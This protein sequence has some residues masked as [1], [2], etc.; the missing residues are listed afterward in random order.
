MEQAPTDNK[1]EYLKDQLIN[2]F[3]LSEDERADRLLNIRDL[4]NRR[5]SELADTIFELSR[6]QPKHPLL[7]RIFMRALPPQLRNALAA[8]ATVDLRDLALEADR[9]VVTISSA[10]DLNTSVTSTVKRPTVKR[11]KGPLQVCNVRPSAPSS[12]PLLC[13]K[14]SVSQQT[15]LVDTGAQVSVVPA[16][17]T[18]RACALT[19]GGPQ[20]QAANG[21]KIA[22]YGTVSRK[23]C[24]E[25]R[26]F[27]GQFIQADVRRPLLG[28]DFLLRNNLLVDIAGQRLVHVDDL[29]SIS[30]TRDKQKQ[31]NPRGLS[32]VNEQLDP[33]RNILR[34]FPEI[35]QPDFSLSTP[36]HGVTH[37][38]PT[39]GPPV[40][41][42]PRRL[43][44]VK[45]AAAKKEFEHLHALGIIRPS[46][47]A[48]ASPLHMVKKPNGE[49][50][51]CGDYRRLNV[52]STP[53]RYP[54]PHIQDFVTRLRGAKVFST[55]D[56]V[57]GYHQILMAPS[58]IEKTAI[59]TP[60]GLWEFVRMPFGLRN[61]G[62]T[63]Q[64]M[65]DSVLR[66]LD[67]VFVY[68]DDVLVASPSVEEH[69]RDLERVFQRLQQ[70]GLLLRPDKCCF[71]ASSVKFLGHIVDS[72]GI[73]PM[74]E[75][76]RAV[77]DFPKP[78]TV[79]ELRTFLGLINFYHRFLPN[80]ASVLHP[81]N[82]LASQRKSNAPLQWCDVSSHA[83]QKAKQLLAESTLLHHPDPGGALA[84]FTDAS[85]IGVGAS[86]QQW[87]Q[88]GW[89]PLAFFSRRLQPRERKYSTFDR[90]LLAGHL[91]AR[92]FRHML[93]GT[94][95]VLYT[96]HKP[97]VEAWRKAGDAW[98]ARQQRHLSTIAEFFCDV[99]Y[100]KG[101]LNL[102]AD[103]LSRA[104][105]DA[106]STC[107]SFE[108][109]AHAQ[110]ESPDIHAA[111]T[112]ITNLKLRDLRLSD[113]GPSVLCDVSQGHPRPLIPPTLRRQIF[114]S[115]HGLSHPGKRATRRLISQ[116]YVWH[117]MSAD[118]NQW[119]KD[120][121]PCHSSKV[122]NHVHSPVIQMPVPQTPFSV[123]HV[124]IVGPLP[125]SSGYSYL[126]TVIDRFSRW[127]EAIP[128]RDITSKECAEQ[129][130]LHWVAR[131]GTPSDI[132]SDRGRQ[133]TSA[134]WS[135]MSTTLKCQ[136]HHTS[137][138]HPQSNG[139]IERWHR[140]LKA[141]LRARLDG[142]DWINQLP[143][144]LLGL[145]TTPR[146][147]SPTS[148]AEQIYKHHVQLPGDT[149]PPAATNT[150]PVVPSPA[151]H[152]SNS[153]VSVPNELWDS[154]YVFVRCDAHR[155]PLERPYLGP[156]RVVSRT[157]K[158]FLLDLGNRNDSVSV[159]RLKPA[160]SPCITRS[161]RVSRPPAR[162]AIGGK[163]CGCRSTSN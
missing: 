163:P 144:V 130:L 117:R 83:F 148:P 103:A 132:I 25:G 31:L 129:F 161:G 12:S 89:V 73:R 156:Y 28:A 49:W 76:V 154:P 9:A 74:P 65:M 6:S 146:D 17:D 116:R 59:T 68:I 26:V 48:Y 1:Y 112:S 47:S 155:S 4:G 96:D 136:L 22:T 10:I 149:L 37:H 44:P 95:S 122:Q 119:C 101:M 135:H 107:I 87:Q 123:V 138:Y 16:S 158:T 79:S 85:D 100:Q 128:L 92:H 57:R 15:F 106:V 7:R 20:L 52:I 91:A 90:E 93:E 19:N 55:L 45:L 139:L 8:S 160:P 29:S 86:L 38:I 60:F 159:D 46:R 40:W 141:S 72:T 27:D 127:P 142:P 140:S 104:P 21:S 67:C 32:S 70:H 157:E 88:G 78:T 18:D 13:I 36:K 81:L 124:D 120:C 53:D 110:Q 24:F 58:D 69:H 98:S 150:S 64:R 66:G 137:A 80:A 42:H 39:T 151:H 23:V 41:A 126:L 56:L 109:I 61:A 33:F 14:D 115:I 51:P 84:V 97:L 145:R 5:P 125:V 54:V 94:E 152:H 11:H 30:C 43:D 113:S 108:D 35:T 114:D 99:H 121:I 105:V 34:R 118:I 63:F 111:R 62:Q 133:F 134:L 102:A 153:K 75:K 131:F 162:L 77:Q 2:R 3:D 147:D 50:R 82:Q 143:W 71:G